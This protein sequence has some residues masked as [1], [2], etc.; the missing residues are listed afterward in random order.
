MKF[1]SRYRQ[2]T[3]KKTLFF[4][5]KKKKKKE[6]KKSDI[7]GEKNFRNFHFSENP[8][9]SG[10]SGEF[11]MNL[12]C[13]SIKFITSYKRLQS[14]NYKIYRKY[15]ENPLRFPGRT[16]GETSGNFGKKVFRDF[17]FSEIRE[18]SGKSG[19]CTTQLIHFSFGLIFSQKLKTTNEFLVMPNTILFM[20][21][22][23]F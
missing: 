15:P 16:S 8:G 2:E 19:K 12:L 23:Y 18:I 13:F 14:E 4:R 1:I 7:F 11:G 20:C 17:H 6:K 21:N 22:I 10:K 5:K 3:Q 9:I